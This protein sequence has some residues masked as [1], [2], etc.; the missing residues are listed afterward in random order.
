[1]SPRAV[2]ASVVAGLVALIAIPLIFGWW[3]TIDQGERGVILR[4]GAIIGIAQPGLS[5]KMP[6]IDEIEYISL[7]QQV[8]RWE[9]ETIMQGYSQDQQPADMRVSVSFH[10][11]EPDV[12]KLYTQFGSLYNAE[13]RL[14]E[15]LTPPA[16]KAVF[17]RYS[18]PSVIQQRGKFNAEVTEAVKAAIPEPLI[19]DSVQV[20]N[21]DFSDAYEQSV[22]ARMVAEQEVNKVKQNADREKVQAEIAVT[23][24]TARANAVKIEAEA[25]AQS[26]RLRGNA[27]ADAIRARGDAL[28]QNPSLVLLTQAEKWNGQLPNTMV[29]GST[30]PFLNMDKPQ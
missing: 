24:A 4:N 27:E 12:A 6:I 7:Q 15:R 16:I 23:Q 9:G 5:F 3:Y 20:E 13:T 30:V 11:N 17:G 10:V 22:E 25:N 28:K 1:M 18:A 19:V 26:I 21:I 2:V 29:P 14:I 8:H